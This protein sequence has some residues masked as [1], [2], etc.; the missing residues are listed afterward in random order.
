MARIYKRGR[1][2]WVAWTHD[3][4]ESLRTKDR[5][6]AEIAVRRRERERADP[7][8]AAAARATV[9]SCL[10]AHLA[11][12]KA[13]GRAEGTLHS[14]RVKSG[15]LA[16]ILGDAT[17]LVE[18]TARAC[19]AYLSQR[20]EEGA[21]QHT[22]VKELGVLRA[23]LRL[24]KRRGEYP[25]DLAAVLPHG[26]Q[27]GYEPRQTWLTED[28]AT[29]LLAEL[30]AHRAR[31]VA[32]L[33]ATGARWS[34]SQAAQR[35]DVSGGRV[36][37]RD[38]KTPRS[39]RTLEVPEYAR[40][41]LL[42]ALDGAPTSG[43]LHASWGNVRRDLAAACERA[44]VPAV[45]PNDLRRTVA[46]WLRQRGVEA[47]LVAQYLGHTTGRMVERVYGR[48]TTSELSDAIGNRVDARTV[49]HLY[50]HPVQSVEILDAVERLKA[51]LSLQKPVARD[52]IEPP[53]RGFSIPRLGRVSQPKTPVSRAR[54]LRVVR[55]LYALRAAAND[56]VRAAG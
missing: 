9:A 20:A 48:L 51:A 21:S 38:T 27:T 18:V 36:L 50:A 1:T 41:L 26:L 52:G 45:T 14:Y 55:D 30:P 46:H 15:H 19:D 54:H 16:R 31:H 6:T 5:T 12:R 13:R 25:H 17:P 2:Y 28:Q 35:E 3:E 29:R 8:H 43:L 53:T 22:I 7:T 37:V 33:L 4:R 40:P 47:S 44:R 42:R 23:A 34:G 11:D 56:V 24:A 39:W 10:S 49:R 32:W